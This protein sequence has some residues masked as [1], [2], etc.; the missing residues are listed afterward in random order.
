MYTQKYKKRAGNKND[1]NQKTG[2]VGF[3]AIVEQC[4][5]RKVYYSSYVICTRARFVHSIWQNILVL[6]LPQ[7]GFCAWGFF[8]ILHC[9]ASI[10]KLQCGYR[11]CVSAILYVLAA[12]IRNSYLFHQQSSYT[13]LYNAYILQS[14]TIN[15]SHLSENQIKLQNIRTNI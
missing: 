4:T 2:L 15:R 1:G 7:S 13:I 6:N 8:F 3:V 11:I 5:L 9:A 14:Q 12:G 10:L